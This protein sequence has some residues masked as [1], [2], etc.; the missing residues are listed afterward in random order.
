LHIGR[1]L[2]LEVVGL[3]PSIDL[4]TVAQRL[5]AEVPVKDGSIFSLPFD[6]A[7]LDF[8]YS[9]EV[10][11]YFPR[12]DRLNAYREILRVLRPGGSFL[13]TMSNRYALDGFPAYFAAKR[14]LFRLKRAAQPPGTYFV[15]PRQLR[16]ELRAAGFGDV[17]FFGCV[18]GPIRMAYRVLPRWAPRIASALEPLDDKL[19]QARWATPFAG[20]LVAVAGRPF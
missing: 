18:L 1:D 6:D 7:S 16:G 5:N 14:L 10:L 3:E 13:F 17:E 8:A 20:H 19:F 4:R 11:R 12:A 2:G 15:S 9:I